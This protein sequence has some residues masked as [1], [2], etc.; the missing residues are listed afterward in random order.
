MEGSYFRND[1]NPALAPTRGYIALPGMSGVGVNM[2]SN[3]LSVDNFFYQRDGQVVTA[4][5]ESVS[6]NDFLSKLPSQGKLAMDAKV[7]V[8]GVGFYAK[9]MFWTFGLNA[10]VS[11]DMAMSTDAFKALKT[12]GNGT[13]DLGDTALEANAYMDAYLGTSF[14]VH[15]NVNIGIKAKFLLGVATAEAQFSQLNANVTP[16]VVNGTM[17]GTFRANGIFIDN[18]TEEIIRDYYFYML[19]NINNFGAALD[20]GVEVRL[21]DDHLKLSAAVTDLGFIKW[22]TGTT[23]ISG[24]LNGDF[25][26]K[27]FNLETQEVDGDGSYEILFDEVPMGGDYISR[28]NFS[29]NAGVEYNILNNHIAFGVLSHTKFCRTMTYT[30]LTASVN[31]R[32]TNWLSATF[33]HTFLN[34]NRPGVF[35]FA[36]NIHPSVLNIYAGVDFVDTQWV[37]GPIINDVQIPL[38]RYTKSLNA[39]VGVGFNFGR[40]K[41]LKE[42]KN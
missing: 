8:L 31:F 17:S 36:L 21:L 32:P 12:L 2:S 34:H 9:K 13:Y 41:F 26:F 10:N 14:R 18:R 6:A 24:K 39:Y 37:N 1:M 3:F 42:A 38:P 30:E 29:V 40:P 25:S 19:D 23:N 5:H 22:T 27:G 4:F 33:S 20:L 16:E 35:G 28:L 7:N 15:E 11:A